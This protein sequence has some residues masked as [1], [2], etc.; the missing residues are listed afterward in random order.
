M[1]WINSITLIEVISFLT[2]LV[3]VLV[4][5]IGLP[6]QIKKNYKRKSTEGQ[7]ISFWIIAWLAYLLWWYYG[8]LKHDIVIIIGQGLGVLTTGVILWQVFIYRKNKKPILDN[9]GGVDVKS[10][11]VKGKDYIGV[12]GGCLILNDRKEILLIRR[13]GEVRNEAGWWSKPGGGVKFGEKVEEAMIRE[14]KEEL[15]IEVE[16]IGYLPHTD[17]IITKETNEDE[18]HWVAFNFIAKIIN[19]QPKN[20]EP[21]KC[22]KIG[23]FPLDKLPKKITQTTK[24][25]VENYLAGKWIKI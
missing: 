2:L 14:M 7:A 24:E 11:N 16:I 1:E 5:V 17:H 9:E 10:K 6:D 4:K 13:S 15:D 20:M 25:P 18:Q 23:W 8:V 21:H 22:D 12:G 3:G 19:G